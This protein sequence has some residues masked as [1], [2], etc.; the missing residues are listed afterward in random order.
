MFA[1]LRKEADLPLEAILSK[2]KEEIRPVNVD[3][4]IEVYINLNPERLDEQIQDMVKRNTD[5]GVWSDG[6][7]GV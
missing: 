4:V 6:R 7:R 1:P 2:Y 3:I 5:V